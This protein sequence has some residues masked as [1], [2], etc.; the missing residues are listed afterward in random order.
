MQRAVAGR[1][2]L[3]RCMTRTRLSSADCARGG[4][5]RA[6]AHQLQ[7]LAAHRLQQPAAAG[8]GGAARAVRLCRVL[9]SASRSFLLT[10]A[11]ACPVAAQQIHPRPH[12]PAP[13]R[14][15]DMCLTELA[16]SVPVDVMPGAGDPA[17]YSLPQ[18]PLHKCL[19]P[20]AAA[21][22]TLEASCT[23]AVFL[24]WGADWGLFE[25]HRSLGWAD[26]PCGQV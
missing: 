8:G 11:L 19:F 20:G 13:C 22:P 12:P 23:F 1:A 14:D 6:A 15:V 7:A 21:F 9:N 2:R 5:W 18:Q 10:T 4:G 26:L 16:G 25:L 24:L 17:N 3:V